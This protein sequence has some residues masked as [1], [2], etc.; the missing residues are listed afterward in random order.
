MSSGQPTRY[1]LEDIGKVFT[2]QQLKVQGTPQSAP[3]SRRPRVS[4]Q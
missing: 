2:C 4:S 3:A 1:W